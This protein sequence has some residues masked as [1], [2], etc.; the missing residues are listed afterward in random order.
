MIRSSARYANYCTVS[1][2]SCP[3]KLC[4]AILHQCLRI[5]FLYRD[6]KLARLKVC[7]AI[8]PAHEIKLYHD[9][10]N[11]AVLRSLRP[12]ITCHTKHVIHDDGLHSTPQ[13]LLMLTAGPLAFMWDQR[14]CDNNR[15][16]KANKNT[17]ANIKSQ[18]SAKQLGFGLHAIISK[19]LLFCKH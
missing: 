16:P 18:V 19:I 14:P 2:L 12:W 6:L 4:T 17:N 11:R 9:G 7:T 8:A 3:P 1:Y 15:K 13:R 5:K 10:K